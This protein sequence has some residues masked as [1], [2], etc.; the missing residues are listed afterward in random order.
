M[1]NINLGHLSGASEERRPP[2][3]PGKVYVIELVR[4]TRQIQLRSPF[5]PL[6]MGL[7][8]ADLSV[9]RVD[10]SCIYMF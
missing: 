5:P 1:M 2:A 6:R 3:V 4:R 7:I 9:L 10:I 8:Y